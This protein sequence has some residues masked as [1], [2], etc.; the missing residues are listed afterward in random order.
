MDPAALRAYEEAHARLRAGDLARGWELYEARLGDIGQKK[1]QWRFTK[2]RWNGEPF[3]GRTLLLHWEQGF[4]DTLMFVRFAAQAKALGGRVVLVAQK[5]LAELAGTCPGVDEVVPHLGRLPPYDLQLPLLSLPSVFRTGLGSIPAA[6]PYL[7]VPERVP[8]RAAL[9]AA[10]AAS[11]GKVRIGLVWA[12]SP[13]HGRDQERSIPAPALA[14][15]AALPG[16]AW[17]S[18]QMGPEPPPW[19]GMVALAP[20]LR[21]FSDTAY[22]LSGM[23]LVITVDTAVAHLAGAMAIPTLLLLPFAPDFRW[24][25][26]RQDSPWYP[27]MRLYRQSRPGDWGPAVQHLARDL[28][29]GGSMG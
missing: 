12:G 24:M 1:I 11:T 7:D 16:V 26:E 6:V 19:P 27:T 13:V 25:L 22:A 17:H 20:W 5:D 21:N 3:P 18:F 28:G 23:D 10:L 14:P 2:P 29:N 9:A 15:L 8:N 4:G